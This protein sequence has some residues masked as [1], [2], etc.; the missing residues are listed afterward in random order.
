[1]ICAI[2]ISF[3]MQIATC[4]MNIDLNFAA[5][6]FTWFPCRNINSECHR[7]C[8]DASKPQLSLTAADEPEA[9]MSF[10]I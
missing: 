6:S 8:S 2:R 1:M 4:D 9:P 7:T 5:C 10:K 3:I